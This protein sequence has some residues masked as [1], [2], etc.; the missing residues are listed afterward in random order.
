MFAQ[1]SENISQSLVQFL[2]LPT[3]A[4]IEGLRLCTK[5]MT[6]DYIIVL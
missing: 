3:K 1:N 2:L 4:F 5:M 6:S